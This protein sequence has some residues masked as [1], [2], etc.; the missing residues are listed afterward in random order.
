[1]EQEALNYDVVIVGAG[2]AGLSCGIALKQGNPA[3]NVC[4]LEKGAEVGAH[5]LSGAVFNPR[6]LNELLPNW[7]TLGAPLNTAASEDEFLLLTTQKAWPLPVPKQLRNHGN[8][9]IS[10]SQ[11]CRWLA[12]QAE[13][14]G[15][16]IF[17]GFAAT[18]CLFD[19]QGAVCGVQTGDMGIN[20]QGQKQNNYQPGIHLLAKHTVLAE[21]ARGSLTQTIIKH[22][23]LNK[24]CDPQ[25]YGIG[26]KEI[27]E[28]PTKQHRTGHIM[29]SV[30]W[31]LDRKTYGGSFLYHLENNRVSIGLVIGLDYQNPYLSP[32]DEFQRLKTH[33]SIAK[34]LHKGNR[35]SYGARAL[36]EGGY[37]SIPQL[38]FDGGLMIG[39]SAGFLNV[40]QIKGIHNAMK[41]GMCA[42]QAICEPHSDSHSIAK[43]YPKALA[44]SWI[45]DDLY[46]ARNVRPAFRWGLWSGMAYAALESYLLRG[47]APWTFHHH[48]DHLQLKD[49]QAS[50]KIVYP[51]PDGLLSFDKMT[52]L[53]FSNTFHDDD[54]PC[55][56]QLHDPQQ[57]LRVNLTRYD[58][59]EQYYCPAG[60]Y[61]I[62]NDENGQ[63]KLQIN[64]QNCLHCKTCDIKDPTQ[65]ITWVPPEGGGGPNYADM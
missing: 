10:L 48:P 46:R 22:Y 19:K 13:A 56:L 39:C 65:N 37:Q 40:A 59:P 63:K 47:R 54:Q 7:Q 17:S 3:L 14:L 16:E 49:A 55:H 6:A 5:I 62:V 11:L 42:A 35:L 2:P 41:S 31:P 4:L 25:T 15:V 36:N 26:L 28:I 61:E 9:I 34:I 29:H 12:E 23:A 44:Q 58:C 57:A 1:M 52:S 64:A 20:K 53:S 38:T 32:Y 50:Q 30:G 51:K 24:N 45:I 18:A 27:W 43:T 33:P 60:V 8:Y 21:G